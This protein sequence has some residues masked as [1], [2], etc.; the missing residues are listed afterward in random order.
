MNIN[1]EELLQIRGG[2]SS[3]I[4]G[5]VLSAIIRGGQLIYNIGQALGT[6]ISRIFSKKYC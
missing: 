4:S 5:T 2:A 6:S 1:K 3:I